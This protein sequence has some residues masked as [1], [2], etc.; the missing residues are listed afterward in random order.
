MKKAS[1]SMLLCGVLLLSGC[2]KP[3]GTADNADT[4]AA[5]IEPVTIIDTAA[6]FSERDLDGSYDENAAV[7]IQL[8]R[9]PSVIPTPSPS[10]VPG[11]PCWTRGP[12]W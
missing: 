5:N 3:A 2:Q 10:A 8:A 6:L 12:I 7:R 1:V 11:S 9:P 4:P